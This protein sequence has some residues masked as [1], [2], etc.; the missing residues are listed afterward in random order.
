[1]C[2]NSIDDDCNIVT[3]DSCPPGQPNTPPD[4]SNDEGGCGC[5]TPESGATPW[6]GM[7]LAVLLLRRRSAAR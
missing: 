7:W 6:L 1:V 4:D 2:G 5:A 3:E